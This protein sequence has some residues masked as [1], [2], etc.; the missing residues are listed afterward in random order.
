MLREF[1][2]HRS[3]TVW[4]LKLAIGTAFP[5]N[6]QDFHVFATIQPTSV[7][8]QPGMEVKDKME[9]DTSVEVELEDSVALSKYLDQQMKNLRLDF[10]KA[11]YFVPPNVQPFPLDVVPS[12]EIISVSIVCPLPEITK[13][14]SHR[15][16]D[17][18]KLLELCDA[19]LPEEVTTARVA[20]TDPPW[21]GLIAEHMLEF[22]N[23]TS[24]D[25]SGNR[26]GL[27]S[28][29]CFSALEVLSVA[30]NEIR[31][32]DL[33][34]LTSQ[35]DSSLSAPTLFAN[36][37]DL[38]LSFNFLSPQSISQLSRL[39]RLAQLNLA[40]NDLLFLPP[41]MSGF[42]ALRKLS[43]RRNCLGHRFE[44][45]ALRSYPSKQELGTT[46]PRKTKTKGGKTVTINS[47]PLLKGARSPGRETLQTPVPAPEESRDYFL[48]SM[49]AQIP[50][51]QELDLSENFFVH[52]SEDLPEGTDKIY[53]QI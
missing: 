1:R 33:P 3:M 9:A 2:I 40:S 20:A 17:G 39:P 13:R 21:G 14:A 23:L 19:E 28:L 26:F 50:Q 5:H 27:D 12:S 44:R 34:L 18:Y 10:G 48:L 7:I 11:K 4:Q 47:N 8:E 52:V 49:L 36:L 38:D 43:L 41:D 51:L 35:P 37:L 30:C 53:T 15:L 42:A 46:A 16:L 31:T 25:V 45:Y 22:V 29:S 32:L 6:Q 24:L